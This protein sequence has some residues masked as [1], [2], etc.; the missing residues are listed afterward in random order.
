MAGRSTQATQP[1][2]ELLVRFRDGDRSAGERVLTV[3]YSELRRIAARHLRRERPDHSLQPTAL[4]NEAYLRL[5]EQRHRDWTSRSHFF[6]LAAHLMR[7]ILIDHARKRRAAKRGGH[8][9]KID[10]EEAFVF[11]T[12]NADDL[13]ALDQ[14]LKELAKL[15]ARAAQVVEVLFFGGLSV[16][17]TAG[18]LGIGART[19]LRDWKSARLWL[20]RWLS[21]APVKKV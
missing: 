5:I 9:Q 6:G 12:Q 2:T 17:E 14:A 4:V 19:V 7:L 1:I 16:E 3:L 11:R 10:L 18:A 21:A 20:R 8:Q 15:D 13:L